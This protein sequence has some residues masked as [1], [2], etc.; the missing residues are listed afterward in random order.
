MLISMLMAS[1]LDSIWYDSSSKMVSL[2]AGQSTRLMAE[3]F[4]TYN[5]DLGPDLSTLVRDD[6]EADHIGLQAHPAY[7]AEGRQG[8]GQF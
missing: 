3:V 7:L 8:R 1:E 6:G 4:D 5:R 2:I